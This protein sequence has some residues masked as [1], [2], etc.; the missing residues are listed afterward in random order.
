MGT[1]GPPREDAEVKRQR[2]TGVIAR[3]L[4]IAAPR[5][6]L[7]RERQIGQFNAD[8]IDADATPIIKKRFIANQF[9]YS[10]SALH[11]PLLNRAPRR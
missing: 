3:N 8:L 5:G 9:D 4:F 7:A 6:L 2:I 10:C 1:F 11:A